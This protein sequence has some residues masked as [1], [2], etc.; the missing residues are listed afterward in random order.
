MADALHTSRLCSLPV[1]LKSAILQ[2]MDLDTLKH[3]RLTSQLWATLGEIYLIHPAFTTFPYRNDFSRLQAISQHSVYSTLIH[4]LTFNMGE[5]NEF[6]A[7]HQY[8]F[9][10]YMAHGEDRGDAWPRYFPLGLSPLTQ[11][12]AS[13]VCDPEILSQSFS[14]LPNLSSIFVSLTNFPFPN[15]PELA[16]LQQIWQ[17]PSTRALPR[18]STTQRFTTILETLLP[19]I[20]KTK[21]RRLK[22]DSLPVEFFAQKQ[23]RIE[24][25]DPIF[26]QLSE[27][28]LVLNYSDLPNNLHSA[29]ALENLARCLRCARGLKRLS[30]TWIGRRKVDISVL[31]SELLPQE[32]SAEETYFPELEYLHLE[33]IASP[34][35]LLVRFVLGLK[36]SLKDL[37]LGGEGSHS[38]GRAPNGGVHLVT[39]RFKDL[40]ERVREGM[41]KVESEDGLERFVVKGDLLEMGTD[42]DGAG[43]YWPVNAW[44]RVGVLGKRVG[45][46]SVIN[47]MIAVS[48]SA[49]GLV[50]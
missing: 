50:L 10:T 11:L 48:V 28:D 4:S 25:F 30:L 44:T 27:I 15:E 29:K 16:I 34:L 19:H 12:H 8:Y 5:L 41:A 21:L 42:E 14:S 40:F 18:V 7:R 46:A 24:S 26:S 38:P 35:E 32:D 17:S 36:G 20:A 47:G 33:G 9:T 22:H 13:L 6:H 2:S 3:M 31:F 23:S 49:E 37:E 39:G 45:D 1:E 43:G